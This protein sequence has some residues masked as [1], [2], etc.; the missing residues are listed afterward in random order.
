[1]EDCVFLV[2]FL[3]AFLFF[4]DGEGGELFGGRLLDLWSR[5]G[6]LGWGRS[7]ELTFLVLLGLKMGPIAVFRGVYFAGGV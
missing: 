6:S 4:L 3:L 1:L 7:L 2:L 5:F